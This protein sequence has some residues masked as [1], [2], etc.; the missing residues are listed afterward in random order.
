MKNYLIALLLLI[1]YSTALQAQQCPTASQTISSTIVYQG[2][3]YHEDKDYPFDWS[4][5]N[6]DA[7]RWIGWWRPSTVSPNTINE[8]F[9]ELRSKISHPGIKNS[10]I[11]AITVSPTFEVVNCVGLMY[12][13]EEGQIYTNFQNSS[14]NS[15]PWDNTA[16]YQT[17][18]NCIGS[19]DPFIGSSDWMTEG[20]SHAYNYSVSS[21]QISALNAGDDFFS[22]TF[23]PADGT[24][25][26]KLVSL[27]VTIT[28]QPAPTAAFNAS[29][30]SIPKGATVNFTDQS[31]NCPTQWLWTFTGGTPASS[32]TQNPSGI[33]YNNPGTYA[34]TLKA[35]NAYGSNSLTK[36]A[37]ITV[38][39]GTI[40]NAGSNITACSN[41]N[42]TLSGSASGGTAPYTYSWSKGGV[43]VGTTASVVV[44]TATTATYT[45]TATDANGISKTD[46]VDVS[47]SLPTVNAGT[48]RFACENTATALSATATVGLGTITSYQWTPSTGLSSSSVQNPTATLANTQ[49]YT[50]KVTDNI[51]CTAQDQVIVNISTNY[52]AVNA[53]AD[54]T[55]CDGI[56]SSIG[57]SPTGSGA[58]GTY[59]YAWSP[60]S[61]LNSVSVANPSANPSATQT[62]TVT[63]KDQLGCSASDAMVVTVLPKPIV[64]AGTDKKI[65]VG[66]SVTI[67]G[68][69]TASG[70]LSPFTYAWTPSASLNDA[71]SANPISTPSAATEYTVV[72]TG[73]NGCMNSDKVKVDFSIP[74]S[75]VMAT[76]TIC[77][78]NTTGVVIGKPA[79]A[80]TPAYTY[81]WS[82]TTG[83]SDPNIY[84]ALAKPTVTTTYTLT[85]TDNLG[86]T[87][88]ATVTVNVNSVKPVVTA[89]TDKSY[90]PNGSIQLDG[91]VSGGSGSWT[92][93]WTP[94]TGLSSTTINNP[95]TTATSGQTYTMTVTDANGCISTDQVVTTV[96][97][98]MTITHDYPIYTCCDNVFQL[99]PT[100]SGSQG[101]YTWIWTT[102][103]PGVLTNANTQHPTLTVCP[104][105]NGVGN[106]TDGYVYVRDV[107]SCLKS[108][109]IYIKNVGPKVGTNKTEDVSGSIA[110]TY[111][112]EATSE[113]HTGIACTTPGITTIESTSSTNLKAGYKIT[114]SDGFT[115]KNGSFFHAQIE[116]QCNY[117]KVGTE[118]IAVKN[119]IS[120]FPNPSEGIFFLNVAA[121][122]ATDIQVEV[123]SANGA[124][125]YN[126]VFY[127]HDQVQE[128]F[129]LNN[130]ASGMYFVKVVFGNEVQTRKIILSK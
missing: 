109:Y 58:S 103:I 84:N 106:G 72:V 68:A 30:L 96:H 67:G 24:G 116:G 25:L 51:G 97:E 113:I 111:Q 48:D 118:E 91:N 62:Y 119:S 88:S 29:S 86:C 34:V 95:T 31:S 37:Y 73:S 78:D 60:A 47:I 16:N 52:P 117:A 18:W 101:P 70:P 32:T 71:T 7:N 124:L 82:P 46:D 92:I 55:I 36:T 112:K 56:S 64:D 59:T 65:C 42:V 19:A 40:A 130:Y 26:I 122:R 45:L 13:N 17:L 8:H 79:T 120:V 99:D 49:T 12:S 57:G 123:Y 39:A 41:Q 14:C 81:S 129:D 77:I 93:A 107:Y 27:N 9:V 44:A 121:E 22:L 100:V 98:E 63:V 23:T 75:N 53:G 110:G 127:N 28:Y 83:L 105:L 128:S 38:T 125:V 115:A 2:V 69:P 50:V 76:Q 54:V 74:I 104:L 35:T 20:S 66:Q 15:I 87:G 6:A 94:S 43:V 3:D 108:K 85:S 21:A 102:Y 4:S 90:C 5:F 33:K 1:S 89:G 10:Q 114:L 126:N 61:N 80:G 11:T